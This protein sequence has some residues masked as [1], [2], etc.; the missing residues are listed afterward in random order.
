MLLF[1]FPLGLKEDSE[2]VLKFAKSLSEFQELDCNVIGVTNGSPQAIKNW[3]LRNNETGGNVI[4]ITIIADEDLA[5]S[6][7]MGVAKRGVP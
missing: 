1:F 3:I 2:E 6:M 4:G 5:L 7:S